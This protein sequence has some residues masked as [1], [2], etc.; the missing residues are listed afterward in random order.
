MSALIERV[1]LQPGEEQDRLLR[2]VLC[3][4]P[5]NG[6]SLCS[7]DNSAYQQTIDACLLAATS[8]NDT[9]RIAWLITEAGADV[10]LQHDR[11]LR[12]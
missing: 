12:W 2:W 6:R 5:H 11:P 1:A 10:H 4:A 8:A 3:L 9:V 7:L